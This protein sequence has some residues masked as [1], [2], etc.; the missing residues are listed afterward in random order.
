[1]EEKFNIIQFLKSAVALGASDE[2]LK[3]GQAP[4]IRKNGF[5]KKTNAAVLTKEDIDNA[6]LE[7]APTAIRDE[8][9]TLCDVDFMFEI[10]GCSRFRI[11]YNRQVGLPALVIRN[12]PYNISNLSELSLPSILK[13]FIEYKNGIILVTGPTGCGKSTT[14]AALINQIN[15]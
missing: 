1:M 6:I 14:I 7:I 5:I 8:I 15:I 13:K 3:V 4:Y 12:I 11:N 10:K 9:L 2:H